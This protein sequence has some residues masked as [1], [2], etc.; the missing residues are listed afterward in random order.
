MILND[1]IPMYIV[2]LILYGISDAIYQTITYHYYTSIFLKIRSKFWR[3]WFAHP[4]ISYLNKYKDRDA[5]ELKPRF[6]GS[7]TIFVRWTDAV[8][9]FNLL[10]DD[11]VEFMLTVTT[12]SLMHEKNWVL[13][14]VVFV[15][16]K[17][18]KNVTFHVLFH[19]ILL[20]KQK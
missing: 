19:W 10:K 5:I 2:G 15:T 7:T 14:I 9:F 12:V 11:I 17:V 8:H 1:L 16:Y 20:T 13:Y 6:P 4:D 18:I 3:L